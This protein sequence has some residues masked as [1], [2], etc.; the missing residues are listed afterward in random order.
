[1]NLF[2]AFLSAILNFS[3]R[4][5]ILKFI[6]ITNSPSLAQEMSLA[7]VDRIMVDLEINGKTERQ[8]HLD[9]VISCHS[10]QDITLVREALNDSYSAE[11]MVRI[12]P[13][14]A[15]SGIE[16]EEVIAR[17]A[18][19]I[20]LPMF[21]HQDE[22][23]SCLDL[24]N[25]RVPLTLLLETA[26]AFVRLPQLLDINGFDDIHFG[27]NDL[28]LDFGLD[29][30]FELFSSGLLDYAARLIREANIPFGI[31]GVS[32]LGSGMLPAELILAAHIHMGSEMVILSRSF[33]RSVNPGDSLEH[34]IMQMRSYIARDDLDFLDLR[35]MLDSRVAMIANK[36]RCL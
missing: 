6:F 20:M 27:L 21:T 3:N 31:G 14:S 25:G 30:M 18:D 26:A 7:G 36:I 28:H 22:V 35:K 9:T 34:H 1:M 32:C 33:L 17:G 12:N 15:C 29:F 24:I 19:R 16:I 2:L 13:I 10:F 11:L 23:S 8:G 5:G 4:L